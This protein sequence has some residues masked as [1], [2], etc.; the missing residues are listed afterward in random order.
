MQR[1]GRVRRHVFDAGRV[2]AACLAAAVAAAL[3]ED[4]LHF[5]VIRGRA[6]EEID[7]AGPGDLDLRNA[8]VG[9][10]RGDERGGEVARLLARQLG[11]QQRGIGREVAVVAALGAFD[12]E[13]GRVTGRQR[14]V[15]AQRVE[16]AKDEGMQG[17]FQGRS[18]EKRGRLLYGLHCGAVRGARA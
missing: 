9:G 4:A 11:E 1:A 14:A 10:Q 17:I 16:R 6:Q 3:R 8:G 5:R 15:R 12:D 13:R 2:A 7:E 18:S